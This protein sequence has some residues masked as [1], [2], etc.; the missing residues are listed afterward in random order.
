MAHHRP[1]EPIPDFHATHA[2]RHESSGDMRVEGVPEVPSRGDEE[3][4]DEEWKRHL[5]QVAS[6]RVRARTNSIHWDVFVRTALESQPGP[7]VAASLNVSLTNV[8]AIKSRIM[9]EIKD[10]IHRLGEE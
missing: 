6:E 2:R 7:E 3:E 10:E 5:F 9:K 1:P 4:W 8:Y